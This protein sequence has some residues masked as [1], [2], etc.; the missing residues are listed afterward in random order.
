MPIIAIWGL[1]FFICLSSFRDIFA[2]GMIFAAYLKYQVLGSRHASLVLSVSMIKTQKC[3][4]V[5]L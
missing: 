4:P 2:L 3:L 1:V 5:L